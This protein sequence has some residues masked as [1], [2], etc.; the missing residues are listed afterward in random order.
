MFQQNHSVYDVT[1]K[2]P[3]L[4]KAIL[5]AENKA[6]YNKTTCKKLAN[7]VSLSE[8][9]ISGLEPSE[10]YNNSLKAILEFIKQQKDDPTVKMKLWD[11]NDIAKR[12]LELKIKLDDAVAEIVPSKK[13]S[14]KNER[15]IPRRKPTHDLQVASARMTA[16]QDNAPLSEA[17][18]QSKIPIED[19]FDNP[20]EKFRVV[21]GSKYHIKK[22]LHRTYGQVAEKHVGKAGKGNDEDFWREIAIWRQ[23]EKAQGILKFYGIVERDGERYTITEWV[24]NGDMKSFFEI[25]SEAHILSWNQKA[26][27]AYQIAGALT[28]CHFSNIVHHDVRSHNILL[29]ENLNAKLANFAHA[30]KEEDIFRK[31]ILELLS[32]IRWVSPER[33]VNRSA[34]YTKASDV[35]SY[36]I[37]LWEIAAQRLPFGDVEN[38]QIPE[39]IKGGERPS[40]KVPHIPPKYLELMAQAWHQDPEKRPTMHHCYVTLYNILLDMGKD[41]ESDIIATNCSLEEIEFEYFGDPDKNLA[42]KNIT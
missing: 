1:Q 27:I 21:R 2:T 39:K 29:D 22:R 36:A 30:H 32:I 31:P 7:E 38:R 11:A 8:E 18:G 4:V 26:K 12:Y 40:N 28:F 35:Y 16:I 20:E 37:V 25:E 41:Q 13:D 19:I 24:K 23:L 3:D 10:N 17:L 6:E 9:K 34:R 15:K 14:P 33:I 42:N 5:T